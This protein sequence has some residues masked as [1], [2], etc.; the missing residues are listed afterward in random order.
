MSAA[1][2]KLN[3]ENRLDA[4]T[5]R[6]FEFLR[7]SCGYVM[8]VP[9]GP[10]RWAGIMRLVAHWTMHEGRIGDMRGHDRRFCYQTFDLALE[11]M[12]EWA[13]R[14]F[15]GEPTF[16]HKDPYTN[17]S[18]INGDPEL[19]YE[20]GNYADELRARAKMNQRP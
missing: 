11:A 3:A 1:A 19:E 15:D 5:A 20:H 12:A 18:R 13:A 4:A 17:R 7:D 6:Y 9:A 14:E 10:G 16:W 2:L 8:V